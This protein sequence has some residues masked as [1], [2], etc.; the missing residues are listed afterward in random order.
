MGSQL[1][2]RS[3]A[4]SQKHDHDG[5]KLNLQVWGTVPWMLDVYVGRESKGDQR[6]YEILTWCRD[7]FGPECYPFGDEIKP[8]AWRSGNATIHGW[9]WFGFDTEERM[10]EF[11]AAWGGT[12]LEHDGSNLDIGKPN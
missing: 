3:M 9:Q 10:K 1:F 7:R 5:G 4:Y 8:G 6:W 12:C 2:D 11:Q